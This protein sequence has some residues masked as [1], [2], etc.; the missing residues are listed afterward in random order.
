ML[1]RTTEEFICISY[2]LLDT[3]LPDLTLLS[4]IRCIFANLLWDIGSQTRIRKGFHVMKVGNIS[5]GRNCFINRY[6]FFDNFGAKII[7]GNDCSIGYNNKFITTSHIEK[8]K[9]KKEDQ[10]FYSKPITIGNN[11]W[12]T[13]NCVIL[14]GTEIGDNVILSAGS[15]ASGKLENGWIFRGNPAE[16]VRKTE[17]I[18]PKRY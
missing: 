17:G 15:V 5:I 2:R 16:K 12:I 10:T 3:L 9:L 7:I 13:S 4:P 1:K 6:N 14:P 18:I 11:V 8:N